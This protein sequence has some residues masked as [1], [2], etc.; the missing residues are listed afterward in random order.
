MVASVV[1]KAFD[2][3][4]CMGVMEVCRRPKR[5]WFDAFDRSIEDDSMD[6]EGQSVAASVVLGRSLEMALFETCTS[7]C[8]APRL[9]SNME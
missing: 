7:Y 5:R 6:D 8:V 2:S 1:L 9:I 3:A 4:N